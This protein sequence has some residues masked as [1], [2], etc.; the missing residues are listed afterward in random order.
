[1]IQL[2]V[3]VFN[4]F[5][6][7]SFVLWDHSKSCIIIDPGCSNNAEY[8]LL[9]SFISENGLKPEML[10]NTHCHIDHILGNKWAV[11]KYNIQSYAHNG[12]LPVFDQAE[13]YARMF[14]LTFEPPPV[15]Q[16]FLEDN[17]SLHFGNS[18]LKIIHVPGHSQGSIALYAEAE[19]FIIV[20]DVLFRGS[21][22]RTDLPGGNYNTI[23]Q[24]IK[25]R[26][27]TLPGNTVVYPGHGPV[28]TIKNEH[29]TN[30]FLT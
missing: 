25:T 14:G 23:I 22:G 12:D 11:E 4:D 28:T 18:E 6:E 26:L 27:L 3:F 17:Q 7:N 10:I 30:P 20:G 1:M 29:D 15:I 5:Q 9:E 16:N 13:E 21:I 8:K 19:K 2:K 24:S